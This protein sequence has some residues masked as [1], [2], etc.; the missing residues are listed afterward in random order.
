MIVLCTFIPGLAAIFARR[1]RDF[2]FR[3]SGNRRLRFDMEPTYLEVMFCKSESLRNEHW[4]ACI[5]LDNDDRALLKSNMSAELST[6]AVVRRSG[7]LDL[8]PAHLDDSWQRFGSVV[9]E[10]AMGTMHGRSDPII[11]KDGHKIWIIPGCV[12]AGGSEGG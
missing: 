9:E 5:E 7:I 10:N 6:R 8:L 1:A 12:K 3:Y 2:T 4:R 11:A